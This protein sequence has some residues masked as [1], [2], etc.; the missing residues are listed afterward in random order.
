[1]DKALNG[2]ISGSSVCLL[3]HP[4]DTVWYR[5]LLNE[6]SQIFPHNTNI[7][8]KGKSLFNGLT[9]NVLSTG[10]KAIALYTVQDIMNDV[11]IQ[12]NYGTAMAS[13]YSGMCAGIV[14]GAIANP[15]NAIKVPLQAPLTKINTFSSCKQIYDKHNLKGFYNGALSIF[16]RDVI[17]STTY[18]PV[19]TYLNNDKNINKITSTL[20][21]GVSGV[22]TSYPLNCVRLYKQDVRTNFTF[23]RGLC[24]S[25][26]LSMKNFKSLALL[27]VRIPL[28]NGL[29]HLI[30]M[31]LNLN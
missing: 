16:L 27:S 11:F 18:F 12:L 1:M 14:L 13:V 25:F 4:I 22:I 24:K 21:A 6:K 5:I 10:V 30:Y 8:N 7:F 31:K 17:Y 28:L 23:W 2:M 3:A 29:T 20:I 26:G 9:F 15:I 19:F